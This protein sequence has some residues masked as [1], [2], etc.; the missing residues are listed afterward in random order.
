MKP[1]QALEAHRDDIRRIVSENSAAN[2]RV[3]GSVLHRTDTEDSDLDLLV[4]PTT[5]TTL[6][7]LARIQRQLQNLL[8]VSVDIKTPKALPASFRNRVLAEA[9]PV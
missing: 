2:A 7:N 8:G 6:L 4:D 3:F 5:D 9:A 1:S